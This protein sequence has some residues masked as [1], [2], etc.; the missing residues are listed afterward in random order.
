MSTSECSLGV[1]LSCASIIAPQNRAERADSRAPTLRLIFLFHLGERRRHC[2]PSSPT[3]DFIR[4]LK[5]Y[6]TDSHRFLNP[7]PLADHLTLAIASSNSH[8]S[9]FLPPPASA[10]Q[11]PQ[12]PFVV[13][14]A[15][16][17]RQPVPIAYSEAFRVSAG[18]MKQAPTRRK[19]CNQTGQ[20]LAPQPC[21]RT[22]QEGLN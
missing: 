12:P 4:V 21:C 6:K 13:A 16:Q 11:Y 10:P 8:F 3:A 20:V 19:L 15:K 7:E 9:F 1:I 18:H 17:K 22:N 14:R 5:L 2:V